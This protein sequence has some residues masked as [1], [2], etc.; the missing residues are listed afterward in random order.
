MTRE[1]GK[2]L[3]RQYAHQSPRNLQLFLD[4]LGITENAF[5]YIIDQHRN[6]LLWKRDEFWEWLPE[7]GVFEELLGPGIA[8]QALGGMD[9]SSVFW[10]T[11]QGVSADRDDAYI[12]IGKGVG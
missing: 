4:W 1:D 9:S 7:S 5:N 10:L 6:S 11:P 12:L 3:I 8:D 2:G